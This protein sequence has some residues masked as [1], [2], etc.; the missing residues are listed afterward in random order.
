MW[1]LPRPGLELVSPALAGRFSTTAPPGVSYK[2]TNPIDQ[3]PTLVTSLYINYLLVGPISVLSH[4]G[5]G[6]QH[7]NF[8]RH[9]SGHRTH[10][11]RAVFNTTP[12]TTPLLEAFQLSLSVASAPLW[13]CQ[14]SSCQARS[15]R[16]NGS[17]LPITSL[18]PSS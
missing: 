15:T 16:W 18:P 3:D 12:C 13:G 2:D 1:D 5:I 7:M 6:L 8:G 9:S 4:W 10:S 14:A 11:L 17:L